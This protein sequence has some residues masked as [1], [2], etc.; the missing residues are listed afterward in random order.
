[1]SSKHKAKRR[2]PGPIGIPDSISYE[3]HGYWVRSK[4]TKQL[5]RICYFNRT[6]NEVWVYWGDFDKKAAA[7][8]HSPDELSLLPNKTPKPWYDME[9]INRRQIDHD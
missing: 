2:G 8:G 9:A 4:E 6:T 1:M 5:G 3:K 7:S